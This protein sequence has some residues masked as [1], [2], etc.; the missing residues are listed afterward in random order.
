[1]RFITALQ[2]EKRTTE[3]C[4]T[5]CLIM[6]SVPSYYK[7]LIFLFGKHYL[8]KINGED[9]VFWFLLIIM[10]GLSNLNNFFFVILLRNKR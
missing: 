5:F 10:S 1:M 6:S 7:L 9:Y 8:R 3:K 4:V 2:S